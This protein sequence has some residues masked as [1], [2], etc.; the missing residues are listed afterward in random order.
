MTNERWGSERKHPPAAVSPRLPHS[1]AM[2]Y[3]CPSLK[4]VGVEIVADEGDFVPSCY[5][6][7]PAADIFGN[8]P[9][10]ELFLSRNSSVTLDCGFSLKVPAGYRCRAESLSPSVFMSIVDSSRFKLEL[11][12]AG[13]GVRLINKQ[14]IAKI[15]IEPVYFFELIIKERDE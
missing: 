11:F 10:G 3:F 14:K 15:W 7:L 8:I 4:H 6:G 2:D 1:P 5:E 12:N 9:S 13:E